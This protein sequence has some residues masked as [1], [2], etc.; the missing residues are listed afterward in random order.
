MR[1][2]FCFGVQRRSITFTKR[3]VVAVTPTQH[4]APPNHTTSTTKTRWTLRGIRR[5]Q[6]HNSALVPASFSRIPRGGDLEF[7]LDDDIHAFSISSVFPLDFSCEM[8]LDSDIAQCI[9]NEGWIWLDNNDILVNDLINRLE[10]VP[11]LPITQRFLGRHSWRWS[12]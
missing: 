10:F 1:F 9:K 11:S 6:Q 5:R 2:L 12:H 8:A 3:L 7:Q 4:R